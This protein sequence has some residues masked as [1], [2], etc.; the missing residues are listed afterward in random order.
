MLRGVY[1]LTNF[2]VVNEDTCILKTVGPIFVLLCVLCFQRHRLDFYI[3]ENK[4][5]L[6]VLV[7]KLEVF[8]KELSLHVLASLFKLLAFYDNVKI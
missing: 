7:N 4:L 1:S 2:S 8:S 5:D 3:T 6:V